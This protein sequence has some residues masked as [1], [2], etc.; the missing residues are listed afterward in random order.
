MARKERLDDCL[1]D[2]DDDGEGGFYRVPMTNR[3][4]ELNRHVMV[5]RGDKFLM[6]ATLLDVVHGKMSNGGGDDATLLVATFQFLPSAKKRFVSANITWTFRSDDPAVEV[7]VQSIAPT[8]GWAL[9]PVT[10]N[11]ETTFGANAN[12]GGP[13][14]SPVTAGAGGEYGHKTAKDLVYHTQVDGIKLNMERNS[15]GFDSARWHLLENQQ[16]RRGICRS[17]QVGV[18]LTRTVL[19]GMKPR[20]GPPPTFKS[21]LEITVVKDG[22]SQA[23][24]GMTKAFKKTEEDED[25]VFRPGEDRVSGYFDIDK[26]NLGSVDLTND[27]MHMSLYSSFD[28]LHKERE[29]RKR[30]KHEQEEQREQEEAARKKEAEEAAEKLRVEEEDRKRQREKKKEVQIPVEGGVGPHTTNRAAGEPA[31][32]GP[33]TASLFFFPPWVFYIVLGMV[34]MYIWQRL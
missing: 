26:D 9:N 1:F 10:L 11:L 17:L 24:S 16:D 25:I 33:Q 8:A 28:D 32:A 22:W 30:R 15:G 29:E 3:P 6:V 34:V 13:G 12:V 23:A 20:P 7:A 27:I 31:R 19:K 4:G 5:N 2:F 14:A 21:T 18:L